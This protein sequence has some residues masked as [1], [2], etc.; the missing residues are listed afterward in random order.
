MIRQ[1]ELVVLLCLGAL[2]VSV[3]LG[4]PLERVSLVVSKQEVKELLPHRYVSFQ[5]PMPNSQIASAS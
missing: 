4:T 5:T 2:S 3:A 1:S